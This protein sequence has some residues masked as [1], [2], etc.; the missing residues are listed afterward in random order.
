MVGLSEQMAFS[1]LT[2]IEAKTH[3]LEAILTNPDEEEKKLLNQL[4]DKARS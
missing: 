4:L 2:E 3:I 1:F